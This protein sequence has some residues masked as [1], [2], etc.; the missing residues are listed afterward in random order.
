MIVGMRR[1]TRIAAAA[2][3]GL[4]AGLGAAYWYARASLPVTTGTLQVAGLSAPVDIVR[5]RDAITRTQRIRS[6]EPN[7]LC[8]AIGVRDLKT[9]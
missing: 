7:R 9:D 3:L 5:D 4:L 6:F 8:A 1:A 2:A